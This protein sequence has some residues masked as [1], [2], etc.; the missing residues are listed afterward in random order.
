MKVLVQCI[1][2][3]TR[4][5]VGGW[6]E[7]MIVDIAASTGQQAVSGAFDQAQRF[8][9]DRMF[10]AGNQTAAIGLRGTVLDIP[11]SRPVVKYLDPPLVGGVGFDTD[12]NFVALELLGVS[13]SGKRRVFRYAGMADDFVVNGKVKLTDGRGAALKAMIAFLQSTF[14][15]GVDRTS[16]EV[17]IVTITPQVGN[18][19]IGVVVAGQ[20]HGLQ[21][22]DSAQLLRVRNASGKKL[23]GIYNVVAVV[24]S[25]T[26]QISPWTEPSVVEGSGT[27]RKYTPTYE[28]AGTVS[29]KGIVAR[30]VGRAFGQSR[31]RKFA[32]KA[33]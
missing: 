21:R 26:V 31:A 6:S 33:K 12:A 24:D 2:Q 1:M 11:G 17:P 10:F 4:V 7:G 19:P 23:S 32:K 22:G 16:A 18:P 25:Y 9:N 27:I 14:I 29:L 5:P 13:A 30:K 28:M 20:P 3:I 8:L 15:R